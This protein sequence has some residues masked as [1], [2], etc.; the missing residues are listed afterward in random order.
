MRPVRPWESE[1]GV[2]VAIA[3]RSTAALVI[4]GTVV[5]GVAL[6]SVPAQAAPAKE[7]P[8][9]KKSITLT[10]AEVKKIIGAPQHRAGFSEGSQKG[11]KVATVSY[12]QVKGTTLLVSTGAIHAKNH[13]L[14]R[15]ELNSVSPGAQVV[16]N[17]YNAASKSGIMT[18]IFSAT[19]PVPN[20]PESTENS[21]GHMAATV[22]YTNKSAV[23]AFVGTFAQSGPLSPKPAI[24]KADQASK[25]LAKRFRITG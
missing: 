8:I 6:T 24:K 9:T 4:V 14:L 13:K 21:T 17:K 20:A 3:L 1:I 23:V 22:R 15:K 11:T 2:I 25:V 19:E 12:S 7:V 5:A 18:V 16:K 10:P